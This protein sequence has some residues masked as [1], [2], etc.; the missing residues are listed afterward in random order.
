MTTETKLIEVQEAFQSTSTSKYLENRFLR[1]NNIGAITCHNEQIKISFHDT[2]SHHSIT[3]DNKIDQYTVGDLSSLAIV[4]A[5]SQTGKLSCILYQSSDSNM[6]RWTM[7]TENNDKIELVSL[8]EDFLV[9]ATTQRCIQIMNLSGIQQ[10]SIHL[11]GPIVSISIFHNQLWII[12]HSITGDL[13]NEQAMFSILL[14]I[15]NDH[16]LTGPLALRFNTKLSWMG[17]S[18]SGKCYYLET[19]GHLSMLRHMNENQL[20]SLFILNLKEKAEKNNLTNYWLLGINDFDDKL[21]L[22]VFE[23]RAQSFPDLFLHPVVLI[24]SSCVAKEKHEKI[25][26]L[27]TK[28]IDRSSSNLSDDEEQL[29]KKRPLS[30]TTTSADTTN[31]NVHVKMGSSGVTL[32]TITTDTVHACLVFLI[33]GMYKDTKFGY[34]YHSDYSLNETIDLFAILKDLLEH[35]MSKITSNLSFLFKC[36]TL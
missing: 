14:D 26:Y 15:K 28:L 1:W 30:T 5:S 32:H 17:F 8:C 13:Q 23:L 18:D 12:H 10:R 2:S 33:D 24:I 34:L 31:K 11:Q 22:R 25:N 7:N 19:T 36:R 6:N 27:K 20:E 9:V 35:I 16:T 21:Q 29:R 4:L 3:I